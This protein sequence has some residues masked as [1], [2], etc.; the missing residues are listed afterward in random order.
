MPALRLYWHDPN[1]LRAHC[2]CV[3]PNAQTD[4][5]ACFRYKRA[6]YNVKQYGIGNRS[7]P[8]PR[9]STLHYQALC[10]AFFISRSWVT[11]NT[12]E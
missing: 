7:F 3:P 10:I 12:I 9:A 1:G 11:E 2:N 8:G 4:A 5:D 6:N